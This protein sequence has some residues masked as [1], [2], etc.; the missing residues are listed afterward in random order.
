MVAN[1]PAAL[2]GL[3]RHVRRTRRAD[4]CPRR[5]TNGSPWPSLKPMAATTACR[6]M[7][8]W[9]RTSPSSTTP[10]WRP[11]AA[12]AR[13]GS[14]APT[15]AVR[16]ARLVMERRGH[17]SDAELRAVRDA[18][19]DDARDHRDRAARRA[20]H[21]DQ[22]HQQRGADGDRFPGGRPRAR[23]LEVVMRT[24]TA[25]SDVAFTPAVKA[26]QVRRGSRRRL[27]RAWK[28][29]AAFRPRS[30]RSWRNSSLRS[31][32]SSSPPRISRASP[33]CSI[34]AGRRDSCA[35][36]TS[37]RWRSRTTRATANTSAL[38]NLS[39]Q[40]ARAVVSHRLRR[41]AA[42]EDL[43]H[44]ARGGS[45]TRSCWRI[46]A[47]GIPRA[48]RTGHRLRR[49]R[50]GRELP[51]AHPAALRGRG[52]RSCAAR[53][54]TN[55]SRSSKQSCACC[56]PSLTQTASAQQEAGRRDRGNRQ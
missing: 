19:Y 26:I 14:L 25:S 29:A 35:C 49:E 24:S 47:R 51:A 30:P 11:T 12:A 31:A 43:G 55:V 41:A 4:R 40:S 34:A 48:R 37:T 45:R 15:A 54:A 8:G 56:V 16:F 39:E 53:K 38:G 20:E 42:R 21:L 36:S 18:G 10:K 17:V 1:S 52:R 50:L 9:A 46:D 28:S 6:R 33:T 27:L 7:P 22:L 23:W 44:G 5:R 13:T 2:E 32:A 3:P